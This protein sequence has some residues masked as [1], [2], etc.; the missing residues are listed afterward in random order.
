MKT[1]VT[2]REELKKYVSE[3]LENEKIKDGDLFI[4]GVTKAK[5]HNGIHQMILEI[6]QL[7]NTR[8]GKPNVLTALNMGDD[9]FRANARPYRLWLKITEKGFDNVFKELKNHKDP[10]RQ[11]TGAELQEKTKNLKGKEIL[12][13]FS[14]VKTIT[15]E[16]EEVRPTI[17]VKQFSAELGLPNKIQKILDIEP[18]SRTENQ[19]LE[20][21]SY[22]MQTAEGEPLVD[23]YGNQVYEVNE[24]SFGEDDNLIISKMP[25]V[26]WKRLEGKMVTTSKES[27]KTSSLIDNLVD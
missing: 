18:D 5:E 13:V 14:R 22:A 7:K 23:R 4:S 25:L 6:V 10:D 21:E 27:V 24:L 15:I 20:L 2:S 3:V 12:A 9:R 8:G 17:N 16:G 26:E 11:L 1:E 19:D